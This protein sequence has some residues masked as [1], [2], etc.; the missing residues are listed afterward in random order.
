MGWGWHAAEAVIANPARRLAA[1]YLTEEAAAWFRGL[2]KTASLPEPVRVDRAKLGDALSAMLAGGEK[3]VHQGVALVAGMLEPPSLEEFLDGDLGERPVLVLL[4]QVTDARN[5]GAIM[6]S[7]RAFGAAAVI[8]T[9]RNCPPEGALMLRAASGAAEHVPLIRVVNLARAM[10]R[11][12]DAGFTL[13]AMTAG[14]NAP[15]EALAAERRLGIVMGAEGAG[16]RRL[17]LERADLHA[18]IP[19][20]AAADSLNVSAA[21]AVALFAARRGPGA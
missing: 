4:D 14:G 12:R 15:I 16:L 9:G 2:A 3:A 7:A 21:A 10:E 6:R 11:L 5:I 20:D 17:T 19:I 18:R 13:A 1:L 8:T